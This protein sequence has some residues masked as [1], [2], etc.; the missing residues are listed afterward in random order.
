MM[1]LA[2][3]DNDT[4]TKA[5]HDQKRYFAPHLDHL[6]A[7]NVMVLFTKISSSCDADAGAS[8]VK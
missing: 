1:P 3:S 4:G 2:S 8:D 6:D 5:L 7:R